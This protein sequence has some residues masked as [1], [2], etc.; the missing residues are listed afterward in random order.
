MLIPVEP[1]GSGLP[2]VTVPESLG[3]VPVVQQPNLTEPVTQEASEDP[4]TLSPNTIPGGDDKPIVKFNLE[5]DTIP[6]AP[7]KPLFDLD[8]GDETVILTEPPKPKFN[9]EDIEVAEINTYKQPKI[10]SLQ[11]SVQVNKY[12]TSVRVPYGQSQE[13]LPDDY[14]QPDPEPKFVN[15]AKFPYQ[16]NPDIQRSLNTYK[17]LESFESKVIPGTIGL[18]SAANKTPKGN[19]NKEAYEMIAAGKVPTISNMDEV[20][21][22]LFTNDI[23]N[24][25]TLVTP[26]QNLFVPK[27]TGKASDITTSLFQVDSQ[28]GK[29]VV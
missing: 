4:Q 13:Q 27:A 17:K 3:N 20:S 8:A 24:S 18:P 23:L 10:R 5:G 29:S 15:V 12:G 9:L 14:Y 28:I 25:K 26:P 6:V 1:E 2:T 7:V 11:E 22:E 21:K 19:P 16:L